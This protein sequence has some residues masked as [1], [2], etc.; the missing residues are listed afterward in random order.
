MTRDTPDTRD[1]GRGGRGDGGGGAVRVCQG[2]AVPG[3]LQHAVHQVHCTVQQ[4]TCTLHSTVLYCTALYCTQ[5]ALHPHLRD[6]L[7]PAAGPVRG[8]DGGGAAVRGRGRRGRTLLPPRRHRRHRTRLL[9]RHPAPAAR[10][11]L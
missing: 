2:A 7:A 10:G 5:G 1:Q 11:E 6:L 8:E 9:Q 3:H 4:F